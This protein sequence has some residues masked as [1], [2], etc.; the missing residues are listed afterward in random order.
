MRASILALA[1][2]AACAPATR[3]G[4]TPGAPGQ[5]GAT[6]GENTQVIASGDA[7]SVSTSTQFRLIGA[8]IAAPVDRVWAVLPAVYQELGLQATADAPRR[9]VAVRG[10]VIS[11]RFQGRSATQFFDCGSGQFGAEIAAQNEIRMDLQSTVQPGSTAATSRLETGL[12]ASARGATG[13]NALMA[14][15]H[16]KQTMEALVAERVRQKLGLTG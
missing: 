5:T 8:D 11:R 12:R 15:C 1:V 7:L 13:A 3:G 4:T 16:T 2:L 6:G 10:A 9:T 14:V